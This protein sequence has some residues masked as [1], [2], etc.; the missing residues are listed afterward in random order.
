MNKPTK[1]LSEFLMGSITW[2]MN[3]KVLGPEKI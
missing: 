2:K 3:L 1:S